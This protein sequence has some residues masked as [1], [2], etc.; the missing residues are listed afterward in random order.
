MDRKELLKESIEWL[1]PLG[2]SHHSTVGNGEIYN[3]S[4]TN[5]C[6]KPSIIIYVTP[7]DQIKVKLMGPMMKMLVHL[8]VNE[9]AF[10]HP[11]IKRFIKAMWMYAEICER[12]PPTI[13]D[14]HG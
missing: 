9:L 12:F 3:F 5:D 11:D 1:T 10:K 2:Y 8:Q 7:S 4:N 13:N 14:D 6:N